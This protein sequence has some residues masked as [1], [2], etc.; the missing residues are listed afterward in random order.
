MGKARE[1]ASVFI[2]WGWRNQLPLILAAKAAGLRW[3]ASTAISKRVGFRHCDPKIQEE[4][5]PQLPENFYKLSNPRRTGD[6]SPA[7][8]RRATAR[9]WLGFA[10]LCERL[11]LSACRTLIETVSIV[12]GASAPCAGLEH[13]NFAQPCSWKFCRACTGEQIE[14]L[15]FR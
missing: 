15:G 12:A 9:R 6:K 13:Q 11:I 3:S 8:T 4:S 2:S 14:Q 7:V 10:F 5:I 1:D